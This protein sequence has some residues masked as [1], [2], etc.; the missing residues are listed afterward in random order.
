MRG[1]R[2]F[3]EHG[4]VMILLLGTSICGAIG[5]VAQTASS[6][7][8]YLDTSQPIA[9]RVD[10]LMARMTLKEK[11]GQLNLSCA[12]VKQLGSTSEEKM[13]AARKFAAGTYTNEIG[14]GS[15]FF[16]LA[17]T[18]RINETKRQVEYFNELQRIALTQTRLKIPLMEE[19]EGTHGAR[20]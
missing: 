3:M 15:G 20:F 13:E 12:Y 1:D 9:V 2:V 6:A 18:I 16:T 5:A 11:I 19:E 10:D 4:G 17:D 8:L 7:P 14:P